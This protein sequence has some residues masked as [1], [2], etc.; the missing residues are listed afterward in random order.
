MPDP[1]V[2]ILNN[3]WALLWRPSSAY[4]LPT[5][6]ANGATFGS[7]HIPSMSKVD[8]PDI[9]TIPLYSS[10][11]WGN[12]SIK[13]TSATLSGLPSVQ[14]QSFTPSSDARSVA[15]IVA[16]G[17]LT[18]AGTYEV[19]GTGLVGCAM[20]WAESQAYGPYGPG[21]AEAEVGE[22]VPPQN[23]DLARQYRDQLTNSNHGVALISKYYDHNDTVNLV[24]GQNNAFTRRWPGGVTPQAPKTPYYMQMT[25][26]ATANPGDPDYAIGGNDTGYQE[27]GAYMQGLLIAT[28]QYYEQ[29]DP[30]NA[31][32]YAALATDAAT[33][34][35]YTDQYPDP[36]TA[37][38]VMAAVQNAQPMPSEDLAA[39]PEPEPVRR[40]RLAAERDFPELQRAAMAEEAAQA[41]ALNTYTSTGDFSFSF[42]MPT[43]TFTG[44]VTI[45]GIPPNQI[46]TAKLTSLSAAIPTIK[47]TLLTN[48][49]PNLAADAQ[50]QIDNA[51][52]FQKVLGTNVNAKLG[53]DQVL[54]YLSGVINQAIANIL[55]TSTSPA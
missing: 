49:D 35:G 33:F 50:S 31:E 42:P 23:M 28:C 3:A 11:T 22:P 54:T 44:G 17:E 24:L 53:S 1:N 9:G 52:W 20:T 55:G 16:F 43:L 39:V 7:T 37:D 13:L 12:V 36:M 21:G 26:N 6:L 32:A 29:N 10:D 19:D 46:L 18:F 34:K 41:A 48:T 40:G 5:V 2:T 15:A 30:V 27:H 14:N 4:Y 47:I 51:Q 45:N 38:Q 25:A 8:V